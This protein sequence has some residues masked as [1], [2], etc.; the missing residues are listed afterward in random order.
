MVGNI[1]RAKVARESTLTASLVSRGSAL[2]FRSGDDGLG[3]ITAGPDRGR[4]VQRK[5]PVGNF[6]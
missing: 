2:R 6:A 4:T 5:R 3:E 1:H